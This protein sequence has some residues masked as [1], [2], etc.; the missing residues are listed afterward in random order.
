M[1]FQNIQDLYIINHYILYFHN[2]LV[3]PW[4]VLAAKQLEN[5][6]TDRLPP[7]GYI[8]T[9]L[10]HEHLRESGTEPSLNIKSLHLLN[11][12]TGRRLN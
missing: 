12:N 3:K 2:G 9:E 7:I 8:N 1:H 11:P 4:Q 5:S 10:G 6:S